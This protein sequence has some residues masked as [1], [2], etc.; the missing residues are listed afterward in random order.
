M[1][2][3]EELKKFAQLMATFNFLQGKKITYGQIER[4]LKK[5]WNTGPMMIISRGKEENQTKNKNPEERVR[6]TWNKRCYGHHY[7]KNHLNQIFEKFF[8]KK[9]FQGIVSIEDKKYFTFDCGESGTQMFF[10]IFELQTDLDRE[11]LHLFN[12]F[13]LNV[14][15]GWSRLDELKKVENLIHVDDVTGLYNQRKLLK[16][17]ETAVERHTE[18]GEVF[19]VLFIDIDHFKNVNDDYGHIVGTQLLASMGELLKNTLRESD[20]IYRY[21]GDEFVMLLPDVTG[22]TGKSIGERILS[23]IKEYEF[24]FDVP[25]NFEKKP[26]TLKLT[27]SIG[28]ANFPADAKDKEE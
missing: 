6:L 12:L 26:N 13:T 23:A 7:P 16:D 9:P 3:G 14:G 28:V 19:T 4:F 25:K 24:T 2:S 21:G 8:E 1:S 10:G 17:I 11:S 18:M 5:N 27:V 22:E 15:K 20:L